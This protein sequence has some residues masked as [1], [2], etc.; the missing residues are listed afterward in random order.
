MLANRSIPN[1][2]SLKN[3]EKTINKELITSNY[4]EIND[5]KS[6]FKT[7]QL[8]REIKMQENLQTVLLLLLLTLSPLMSGKKNKKPN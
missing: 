4:N 5:N 3:K 6:Y 1:F 7:K 8:K 2:N